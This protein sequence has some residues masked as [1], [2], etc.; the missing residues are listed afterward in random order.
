MEMKSRSHRYDI[1]RL[2]PRHG[3]K[4]SKYKKCLSMMML[5]C[6]KQQLSNIWNSIHEKVKKS[7]IETE[8]NKSITSK[9]VNLKINNLSRTKI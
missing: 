5:T 4:Y 6:I 7:N 1:N 8:L 3:N 9:L 2:S